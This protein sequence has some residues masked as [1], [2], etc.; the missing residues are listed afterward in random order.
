MM[1]TTMAIKP[2]TPNYSILLKLLQSFE[3]RVIQSSMVTKKSKQVAVIANKGKA[4]A[5]SS[6]NN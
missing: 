2:P 1:F 5:T 3:L 4:I 6:N